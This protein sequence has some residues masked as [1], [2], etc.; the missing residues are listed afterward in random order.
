LQDHGVD[1]V[2]VLENGNTDSSQRKIV[3][4]VN[5]EKASQVQAT[6]GMY[7]AHVFEKEHHFAMRFC[8]LAFKEMKWTSIPPLRSLLWF[9]NQPLPRELFLVSPNVR[10]QLAVSPSR[11][12]SVC[13][14]LISS[15]TNQETPKK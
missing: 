9:L 13:A 15:R 4:L 7:S 11:E 12:P 10:P 2:F 5:G 14:Q 6:A 3:Y 1:K 8:L